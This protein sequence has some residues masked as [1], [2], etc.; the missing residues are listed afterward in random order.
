MPEKNVALQV[1]REAKSETL[2]KTIKDNTF[3]ENFAVEAFDTEA[4]DQV[5]I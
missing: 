4:A 3:H 1:D 2:K 5:S